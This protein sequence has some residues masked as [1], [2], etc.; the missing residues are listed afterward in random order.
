ML[1]P[2]PIKTL[3]AAGLAL[4]FVFSGISQPDPQFERH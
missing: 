1:L 3:L 2:K 4:F